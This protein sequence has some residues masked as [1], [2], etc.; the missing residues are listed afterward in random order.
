MKR[1]LA[2]AA[3]LSGLFIQS[4]VYAEIPDSVVWID[5]RAP[6]EFAT[7]HLEGA[8]NIPHENIAAGVAALGLEPDTPIY[9]YCRSGRRSGIASET[10]GNKGY[11]NLTNVGD[12]ENARALAKKAAN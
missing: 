7:G 3:L 12:L 2:I 5:V 9:L 11:T 8:H 4:G 6:E 1:L 10:L